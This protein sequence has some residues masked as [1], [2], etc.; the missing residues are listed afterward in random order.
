[1]SQFSHSFKHFFLG[2]VHFLGG[3]LSSRCRFL[4]GCRR[5]FGGSRFLSYGSGFLGC[6]SR[7]LGYGSRFLGY[8]SRFLGWSRFLS[9]RS[10]FLGSGSRLLGRSFLHGQ[11][12]LYRSVSLC[13]FHLSGFLNHW[14]LHSF[15]G[16]FHYTIL[17][18]GVALYLGI[19]LRVHHFTIR[20]MIRL[21]TFIKM[22]TYKKQLEKPNEFLKTFKKNF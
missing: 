3:F 21:F 20:F 4:G 15:I 2:F 6:R 14:F 9:C 13:I 18:Y 11:S 19:V 12:L 22:Q 8:G 5:F 7:F 10:G 1:M 17:F 16:V